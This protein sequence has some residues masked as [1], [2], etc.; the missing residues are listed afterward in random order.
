MIKERSLIEHIRQAAA[1]APNR[2]VKK[3]I[4]DDCAILQLKPGYELLVT[5]DLCLEDVHFRSAWHPAT[6]VGHRCLTR[7]LSD[8]AA[9]GG[10]PLACFLSLGLPE[11]LS[12]AWV[13]G[14]L[15]GLLALARR[16]NV[17]L[18]GGDISSAAHIT[19]DIIVTGHVPSGKAVLRSG[20][21]P[22]DRIYVSGFL[23]GSA[24]T[25]KQLF[26]GK[27]V[28]P[29]KASPHFYP[30]PRLEVGNWLQKHGLATAMIDLSD[31]I[32]VDLAHICGESGVAAVVTANKLPIGKT[33]DLDLALH[34]GED[35]ELLFTAREDAKIPSRI[36]G[37]V[38]T[39]IGEIR[40]RRD[41]SS[42][43]QILGDNGKVRPLAQ[44][45]WQHFR[46]SR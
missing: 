24:A 1:A 25:V 37:V 30:T 10:E 46:K 17:Q 35:Y 23:G 6:V 45:G 27:S 12:Q 9:M 16:F 40:N 18:A 3:G 34:G 22:G 38:I 32:S 42:A 31:G 14:F 13:N 8:I 4:G 2:A 5:T 36:A 39:E 41:Y 29:T 43:I 21:S 44:R 33:A 19:A 20:A 28:A 7:G 11:D 26:A 15:R